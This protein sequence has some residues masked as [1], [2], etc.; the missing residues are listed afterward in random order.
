MKI[1]LLKFG[2]LTN[3]NRLTLEIVCYI[4]IAIE[5]KKWLHPA[6]LQ[7]IRHHCAGTP[8]PDFADTAHARAWR[9]RVDKAARQRRPPCPWV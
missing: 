8:P 2:S 1:N 4:L 9:L 6:L 5:G 3:P 7:P